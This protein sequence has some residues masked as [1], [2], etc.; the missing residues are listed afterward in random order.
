MLD[1]VPITKLKI[2]K[3]EWLQTPLKYDEEVVLQD[4]VEE[5][6]DKTYSWLTSKEDIDILSDYSSFK[7]DFINL[8]Y[9]KYVR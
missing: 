1:L 3:E 7:A 5:M 8:L 9:D 4:I 6:C 2:S